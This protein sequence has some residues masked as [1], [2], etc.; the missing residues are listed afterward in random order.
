MSDMS[1]RGFLGA[2][3]GAA[4]GAATMGPMAVPAIAASLG[5]APAAEGAV[6]AFVRP[7]STGSVTVMFG[8]HEVTT[9][10]PV[11]VRRILNAAH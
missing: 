7:G 8:E 10:D 11:L 3:V 2:T 6:V 4:A 9:N 1:R 5:P